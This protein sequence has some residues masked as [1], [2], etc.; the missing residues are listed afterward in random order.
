MYRRSAVPFRYRG[1][2]KIMRGARALRQPTASPPSAS[3]VSVTPGS[4][5]TAV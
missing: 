3:K 1:S 2:E 5:K 4:V